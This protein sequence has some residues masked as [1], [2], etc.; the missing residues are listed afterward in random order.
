LKNALAV[1]PDLVDSGLPVGS[2]L[3]LEAGVGAERNRFLHAG[4][5]LLPA[6]RQRLNAG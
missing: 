6:R 5:L 2:A 4:V 1:D 3:L